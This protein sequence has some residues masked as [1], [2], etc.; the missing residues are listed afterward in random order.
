MR[1]QDALCGVA[2]TLDVLVAL[3]EL[4]RQVAQLAAR[5]PLTN[6]PSARDPGPLESHLTAP[7]QKELL[8]AVD[9]AF[10]LACDHLQHQRAWLRITEEEIPQDTELPCPNCNSGRWRARRGGSGNTYWLCSEC[11][12][13]APAIY[14]PQYYKTEG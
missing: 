10:G 1:L 6:Y 4:K 8:Q 3:E 13:I 14:P 5:A 11:E 9:R 7:K 12:E 2:D